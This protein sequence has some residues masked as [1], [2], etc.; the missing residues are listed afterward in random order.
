MVRRAKSRGDVTSGSIL[1]LKLRVR[2]SC[3][4]GSFRPEGE[5]EVGGVAAGVVA[6]EEE[7]TGTGAGGR[8]GDGKSGAIPEAAEELSVFFRFR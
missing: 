3:W 5:G 1:S 4:V 8:G 6:G 2:K 7:A